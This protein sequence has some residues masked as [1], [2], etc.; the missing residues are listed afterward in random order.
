MKMSF[1]MQLT[2]RVSGVLQESVKEED[3]RNTTR[4]NEK[5][6]VRRGKEY[7]EGKGTETDVNDSPI[8]TD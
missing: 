2:E 7:R 1:R 6:E 5:T 8:Q 3:R 4:K